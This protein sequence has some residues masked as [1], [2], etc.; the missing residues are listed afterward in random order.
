MSY[1]A[2]LTI[3]DQPINDS[4]GAPGPGRP[5][6]TSCPSCRRTVAP[7]LPPGRPFR[8]WKPGGCREQVTTRAGVDGASADPAIQAVLQ[9]RGANRRGARSTT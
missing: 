5:G 8:C 7:L 4:P 6:T 3:V 9:T 2:F 1:P